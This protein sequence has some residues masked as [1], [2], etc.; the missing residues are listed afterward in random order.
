M[1]R[2]V[3]IFIFTLHF[4]NNFGQ[5][6]TESK[7]VDSLNNWERKYFTQ[8]LNNT[9][10]FYVV[11][12][13]FTAD[14]KISLE[15][16]RTNGLPV[17][18]DLMKYGPNKHPEIVKS[19]LQGYLWENVK[20]NNSVLA[21]QISNSNEC[22]VLKAELTDTSNLNYLRD[23]IGIITYLLDN[24]GICVYDPQAFSFLEKKEWNEKIFNPNG[25]VPRNHVMILYSEEDGARWY[26]TRGLRKF[27]RPDLSIHAVT[28]DYQEGV[29]DLFNRFIEYLAFGGIV[30][31][32]QEVKMKNL[33][34][35]MWCENKG[36]F[37]DPEF[38]NK[39]IEIHWK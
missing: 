31:D 3:L 2:I 24:G 22:F 35:G 11:Y 9:F 29:I 26:H 20:K 38:N 1:R 33:P 27:G 10:V 17:G 7:K 8:P 28:S 39:H 4:S 21:N 34:Q 18:A 16:Y 5:N 30:P 23:I 14:F 6:S 12:G 15:R 25:P 13:D 36:D 19:F 37:D 32:K